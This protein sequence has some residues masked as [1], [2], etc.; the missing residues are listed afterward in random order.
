MTDN[1]SLYIGLM[2]GTSL[3][4]VDSVIASFEPEFQ[5]IAQST[6]LIPSD[7]KN[8]I[9]QL[10]H[11]DNDSV[12]LLGETHH[13]L[14][15]LFAQASHTLLTEHQLPTSKIAAIGSHGQTIRHCPEQGYTLQIGDAS[16]IT[17]LTKITTV[18]DFRSRD[19]AAGG[20]GAPLVPAFHQALFSSSEID[21]VILNVGGMANLTYLPADK[22]VSVTGFDTGPGNILM[23]SWIARHQGKNFDKDGAWATSGT[24]HQKLLQALLAQPYF[25]APPP[26]ST[27]RE[28]FNLE[29]LDR[30]ITSTAHH[31]TPADA[32]A[33][34][35]ELTAQS[36]TRAIREHIRSEEFELYLCGGGS[37]NTALLQRIQALLPTTPV[38]LTDQLGLDA[39]WVEAAAFAWLA[40]RC[41]QK[42]SGNLPE[43]TGANGL[44][45]L[46]AI[47]PA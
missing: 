32:Q 22:T 31:I 9:R 20:Q 18:A 23:D 27:G 34:L 21:R 40:Y 39:D 5:L 33:T 10:M 46:G 25:S 37:H 29:W 8:K 43:V 7:L 41:L 11:A 26:K 6:T 14:G 15:K 17:E 45:V 16:L 28:L 35:L 12:A 2:S 24:I 3:D 36:A 47:Y 42:R 13:A 30:L 19:V 1:S 4:S 44:K 38:G